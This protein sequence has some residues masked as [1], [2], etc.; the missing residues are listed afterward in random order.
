M[1]DILFILLMSNAI[2]HTC[3]RFNMKANV[4]H[5]GETHWQLFNECS[6]GMLQS[7]LGSLNTRGYPDR[8]CLTDWNVLGEWDGK[9]RIQHAQSKK[10]LCFNKRARVT[11]RFNGT[12]VKCTFIEEIHENGYSRL[13]SSW[14]PELYLGFNSRGR[15]QNPLSFHLKPR[16]FDWIKL[17]RYV[18]ESEKNVCSAPP[19]PKPSTPIE[20]SPF[21]Y[22]VARSHF[23]KKVSATHESL[24]RFT[25]LK[26]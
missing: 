21:A 22:K 3:A 15:F 18:P 5:I 19:K 13:R 23:L 26:I 10:F 11:L 12:D 14:K 17:V 6:K 24:Y 25:S 1:L 4:H 16:C 8:H 20:H 7:F 9:F 2:G